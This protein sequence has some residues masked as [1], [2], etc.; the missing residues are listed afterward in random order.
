MDNATEKLQDQPIEALHSNVTDGLFNRHLFRS[1]SLNA[2]LSQQQQQVYPPTLSLAL[3]RSLWILSGILI[4]FSIVFWM[5]EIPLYTSMPLIQMSDSEYLA[6]PI[7]ATAL[8]V[9]QSLYVD[10]Q[11]VAIIQS[12]AIRED[13]Q[14]QLELIQEHNLPNKVL[15]ISGYRRLGSYLPL[16][17][18]LFR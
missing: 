16:I 12:I 2:Y 18:N 5:I 10:M 15:Y 1:E 6:Q 7:L 11:E 3:L 9:G 13:G 8:S 14:I 4:I 17:G